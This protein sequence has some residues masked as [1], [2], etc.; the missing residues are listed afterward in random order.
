MFDITDSGL[1]GQKWKQKR[2]SVAHLLK[3]QN[4]SGLGWKGP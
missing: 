1:A 3:P 4:K 2:E